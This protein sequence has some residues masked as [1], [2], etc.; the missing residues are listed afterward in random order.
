ML[1]LPSKTPENTKSSSYAQM[2]SLN[3][4]V[5]VKIINS[6]LELYYGTIITAAGGS[7][8][9]DV[10][11]YKN[12]DNTWKDTA[13]QGVKLDAATINIVAK[14]SRFFSDYGKYSEKMAAS[15]HNIG[16]GIM[17]ANGKIDANFDN[18]RFYADWRPFTSSGNIT[19]TKVN[20]HQLTFTD[21][22]FDYSPGDNATSQFFMYAMNYKILGGTWNHSTVS[23]GSFYYLPLKESNGNPSGQW[24]GGYADNVLFNTERTFATSGVTSGWSDST[25]TEPNSKKT[26]NL[27]LIIDGAAVNFKSGFFSDTNKYNSYFSAEEKHVW[28]DYIVQKSDANVE[29]GSFIKDGANAAVG[30]SPL[31][32]A[33]TFGTDKGTT[34]Y[35]Y[36]STKGN[37][38]IK[39]F[40]AKGSGGQSSSSRYQQIVT[41]A[42][43]IGTTDAFVWEWDVSTD[44][45]QFLQVAFTAQTRSKDPRFDAQGKY[46]GNA[47]TAYLNGL[48]V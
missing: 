8:T 9:K 27:T 45:A 48:S 35:V 38:Y 40:M 42:A 10:S 44:D 4:N 7:A 24:V 22:H 1:P 25:Y 21:C 23:A 28:D 34:T 36:D 31:G 20:Q 6:D 3:D 26:H 5:D 12:S 15:G 19:G 13:A 41:S 37:G 18:C 16:A 2:I 33:Y 30:T 14:N 47:G 46:L 11:S 43:A 39:H 32:T 29:G 17:V